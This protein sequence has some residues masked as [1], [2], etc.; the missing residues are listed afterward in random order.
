MREK[1]ENDLMLKIL[2]VILAFFLWV[3]VI[4]IDDPI[5]RKTFSDVPV[6]MLNEQVLDDLNQTYKIQDGETVSFTV[7]G[8]KKIVD[9]LTKSDFRATA[10]VSSMSKVNAILI[11]VEPLRYKGQIDIDTSGATVK[12]SLEDLKNDQIPV[13]VEIKGKPADGYTVGT[14]TATPNLISVSGP[15]S[16]ISQI[17]QI[18][19]TVDVTGLKK[20]VTMSQ[21]VVCYDED[22][23]VISQNRIN[24]DT[25]TIK[26]SIGLSKTKA[27]PFSVKT[28]GSPAKG[29]ALGSIDYE[30]KE[31]EVTGNED[32]LSKIDEIELTILDI[33]DSTKSIEKTI[34]AS[35][36]KLPEGIS[37]VDT[38]DEVGNIVIKANIEKKRTRTLTL[39]TDQI[40]LINNTKNYDVTFDEESIDVK[41]SGLRSVVDKIVAKDL[42]PKINMELFEPGTH[43]VQVQLTKIKNMSVE[44]NVSAK[45]TVE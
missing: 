41:I 30:P 40:T 38:V 34:K 21:K 19:A 8:K 44:G 29:Y 36:I 17:K 45:I 31:I 4:N 11:D 32:D 13:V 23:D 43:T 15:K 7:R 3:F 16:V 10:D 5:I 1:I 42:N 9:K 18:V 27:V 2:S 6:D 33:E 20:D 26:V 37:F 35:D 25:E 14:Q 12:V 28:K 39:R 22:G 24:L